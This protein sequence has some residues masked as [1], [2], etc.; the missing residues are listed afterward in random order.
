MD[1]AFGLTFNNKYDS[2]GRIELDPKMEGSDSDVQGWTYKEKTDALS[3]LIEWAETEEKKD[4]F[5]GEMNDY[6][7]QVFEDNGLKS[8]S[9]FFKDQDLVDIIFKKVFKALPE[10]FYP[11]D[12]DNEDDED[13]DDEMIEGKTTKTAICPDCGNKYLVNTGYCPTCKKKV[14]IKKENKMIEIKEDVKIGDI[15]LEAGDKIRVLKENDEIYS[16]ESTRGNSVLDLIDEIDDAF[17]SWVEGSRENFT[18]SDAQDQ[19]FRSI[20]AM[21]A[22]TEKSLINMITKRLDGA[23]K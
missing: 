23:V 17:D 16:M 19:G 4:W 1:N 9:D 10:S 2:N 13:D 8:Y 6:F 11:E 15:L 14:K 12:E 21:I 3:N 18:D 7:S 20:E 5:A 22:E